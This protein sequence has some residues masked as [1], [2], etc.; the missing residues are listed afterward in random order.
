[1][2]LNMKYKPDHTQYYHSNLA[3]LIPQLFILP[4]IVFKHNIIPGPQL[5]NPVQVALKITPRT[6]ISPTGGSNIHS[7]ASTIDH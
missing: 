6:R 5:Y 7:T 4:P 3:Y 2:T 1:M